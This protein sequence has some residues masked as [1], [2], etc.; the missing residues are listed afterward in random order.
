M[1]II[2]LTGGMGSGKTTV[3]KMFEEYGIPIYIADTEAKEL[4]HTSS[5]IREALQHLLGVS[6]YKDGQLDRK[7]MADKIFNNKAVLEKVNRIVHPRVESHFQEWKKKQNAPYC[8]KEVAILFENGS[9][10]RCDK[11][12]L[13]V[14][15]EEERISRVMKRDGIKREK[16][17]ERMKNQWSDAEKTPLADYIIENHSLEG[18]NEE[19]KNLHRK[20]SLY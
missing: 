12:I 14:A 3:A 11:T 2:G 7:Y 1:K 19:V 6:V 4:M 10:K 8:I 9:Y 13:V 15:D 18:T 16:V 20:L 5:E 17:L